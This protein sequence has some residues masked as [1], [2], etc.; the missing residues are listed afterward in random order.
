MEYIYRYTRHAEPFMWFVWCM[1]VVWGL[2]YNAMPQTNFKW[3]F[4]YWLVSVFIL[5]VI[6]TY[7]KPLEY[8]FK[9]HNSEKINTIIYLALFICP[10]VASLGAGILSLSVSISIQM[11]AKNPE[12]L[13]FVGF[14]DLLVVEVIFYIASFQSEIVR[15]SYLS[16]VRYV[17]ILLVFGVSLFFQKI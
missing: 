2:A 10:R 14:V 1:A 7:T 11:L 9:A 5:E 17:L 3:V 12:K 16:R 4:A 13:F 15:Q 8:D 6:L